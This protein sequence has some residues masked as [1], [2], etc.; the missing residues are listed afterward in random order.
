MSTCFGH[1]SVH[2]QEDL[3]V[4]LPSIG[5]LKWMHERNAIKLHVQVFHNMNV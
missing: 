5:L 3:Y 2:L 1:P 4:Y